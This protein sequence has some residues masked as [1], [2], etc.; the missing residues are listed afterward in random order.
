VGE[1]GVYSFKNMNIG[2][3]WSMTKSEKK[4]EIAEIQKK[5]QNEN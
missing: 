3:D 5:I 1:N 4:E 2:K